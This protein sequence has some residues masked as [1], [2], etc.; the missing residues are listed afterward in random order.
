M[1]STK[2]SSL[3]TNRWFKLVWIIP[4]AL[5]AMAAVVL[6]AQ[7]LRGLPAMQSFLADYPGETPLPDG[8]PVG[9]PAWLGWQH[10]LNTLLIV[11]IIRSGWQVRTTQRPAAYWTRNNK[12]LIRTKGAPKKISLDLWF[13]QSLDVIWVLN[14]LVFYVLLF[15]T[16]QWMRLIPTSW[17]VFPNAFSAALQY[18][19]LNW[20]HENGWVN[21]NSLQLLAYFVTVFIAAPLA[22]ITGLRMSGAWPANATRLN[23]AYPIE[24]ARAIHFPVM[25][26]FVLF[27][28]VH[29][30]LVLTTGA[31]RNLNHMYAMSNDDASWLGFWMFFASL[32]VIILAWFAARPLFLRPIAALTG[33]VTR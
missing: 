20:P 7:W 27:I 6:V 1:D 28:I 16:G 4:L 9:F 24:V 8:A 17:D 31:L 29:V 25:I 33:S 23:K 18:A 21:Y 19:S 5:L 11:L 26:Y 3:R 10:F 13:H 12:G 22:V 2:T 14:G 15:A 30:V 32:V